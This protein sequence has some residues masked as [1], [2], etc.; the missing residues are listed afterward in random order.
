MR[1]VPVG[2]FR[3]LR[4]EIK[5]GTKLRPP[6]LVRWS[7]GQ[8]SGAAA[9]AA[10]SCADG[11]IA[12]EPRDHPGRCVEGTPGLAKRPWF[13]D[14]QGRTLAGLFEKLVRQPMQ[15]ATSQSFEP[16]L[17]AAVINFGLSAPPVAVKNWP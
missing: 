3:Q 4:L 2:P 5:A 7:K 10:R 9:K 6:G 12:R 14:G 8:G 15:L 13:L 16:G 17:K 1:P 11:E